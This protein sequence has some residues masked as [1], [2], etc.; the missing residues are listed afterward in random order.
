MATILLL[1]LFWAYEASA[2]KASTWELVGE[3][4]THVLYFLTT[5]SDELTPGGRHQASLLS[6]Y[7]LG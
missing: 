6:S 5:R 1:A 7:S 3:T 2:Q 4:G